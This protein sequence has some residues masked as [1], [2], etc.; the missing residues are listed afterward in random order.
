MSDDFVKAPVFG[1]NEAELAT[2]SVGDNEVGTINGKKIMSHSVTSDQMA[3]GSVGAVQMQAGAVTAFKVTV[4]NRVKGTTVVFSVGGTNNNVLQWTSGVAYI[5]KMKYSPGDTMGDLQVVTVQQTISSGSYQFKSGD[6]AYY[7]YVEWEQDQDSDEPSDSATLTMEKDTTYPD[8]DTAI[9]L[10]YAWYDPTL[11]LAQFQALDTAGGG[12][13]ISGNSII[14]GSIVTQNLKS[15]SITTDL[16]AF[17]AFD[18]SKDTLDSVSDGVT[19]KKVS[20]TQ[21][22]TFADG[23]TRAITFIG[24]DGKYQTAFQSNLYGSP[25]N[26]GLYITAEHIG[27][28]RQDL[29]AW[30]VDI[31]NTGEMLLG[32]QSNNQYLHW[33]GNTL[34]VRGDIEA[35]S[36]SAGV[37]IYS[38]TI[39]GGTISGVTI[40]GE[41]ITGGTMSGTNINGV[42]MYG[43]TITGGQIYTAGSGQHIELLGS[44]SAYMMFMNSTTTIGSIGIDYSNNV[45]LGSNQYDVRVQS[46]QNLGL[47][48]Y[49]SGIYIG[50]SYGNN[51]AYF[52][53][54]GISLL[55]DVSLSGNLD[56]GDSY[57]S[58][59]RGGAWLGTS[60]YVKINGDSTSPYGL[61]IYNGSNTL[62]VWTD[63]SYM[64][65]SINGGTARKISYT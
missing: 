58:H 50:Y 7:F 22:S 36:V 32:S 10:A 17:P 57:V 63:G 3:S 42:T 44:N 55:K 21:I 9:V 56:I 30:T 35:N 5:Q 25:P 16:L 19:Y 2:G 8:S 46:W 13:K 28:Y 38:P 11:G 26:T 39:S 61:N 12:V 65:Y 1:I 49:G 18:K 60:D 15:K 4:P 34:T 52:T 62:K 14:S 64:Y 53:N 6:N 33:D 40:S 54:S 47:Y 27:F 20:S 23:S 29:N 43:S 45:V 41:T 31:R 37:S 24:S 59:L 51:Y 48:A